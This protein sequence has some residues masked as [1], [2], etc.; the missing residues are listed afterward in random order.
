MTDQPPSPTDSAQPLKPITTSR[1]ARFKRWIFEDD[2][3][4]LAAL[5]PHVSLQLTLKKELWAYFLFG[6]G[7]YS[8]ANT[9]NSVFLPLVV[10]GL[11]M[12]AAVFDHD[13]SVK[14]A[15][16]PEG[17][18]CVVPF[19]WLWVTPTSYTLLLSVVSVLCTIVLTLGI[20]AHADHGRISNRLMMTFCS[21]LCVFTALQFVGN[22]RPD[23][24]WVSALFMVFCLISNGLT[25]NFYDAHI[26]VLTRHHPKVV[27]AEVDFGPDSPEHIKIKTNM[28]TFLSG[29]AS[30]S[31]YSGAFIVLLIGAVCLLFDDSI[32]MMMNLLVFSGVYVMFFNILYGI[33]SYQR[34]FSPLPAGASYLTF[35]YKRIAKTVRQ[36]TKVPTLFYFLITWL[37]LGDGLVSVSNMAI[38]I[39]QSQLGAANESLIIAAII[40]LV[41]GGLGNVGWIY[42]QNHRGL[43]PKRTVI[44]NAFGFSLIPLYA[45]LGLIDSCPIGLKNVWEIYMLAVFFGAFSAAIYSSNRVVFAQFI[46]L[47]HEN[48]LYA[49][50]EMA[51]V[52]SS[53]IGPLVCT[54]IIERWGVRYTWVFLA[55]QFIIPAFMM[56]FVDVDKGREQAREF[57]KRELARKAE[58][59]ASTT[60]S[61]LGDFKNQLVGNV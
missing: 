11:A 9:T 29:G 4:E 2:K 5:Q 13:H 27:R 12:D 43:T 26:P 14:C 54:G 31:G 36:A 24:W 41:A 33:L 40:Q 10:Q 8:W 49:L 21:G 7:Y 28:A 50:Y 60:S 25:I 47:G 46:P 48:E 1:W 30:I 19:G 35:G 59:A 6:F 18:R 16:A 44:I 42:L 52:T 57:S 37:I 38:L 45:L 17:A 51:S 56:C 39:V 15:D 53:W 22:L 32:S 34:E 55:T 3:A 58:A 20:S 61:E 23:T